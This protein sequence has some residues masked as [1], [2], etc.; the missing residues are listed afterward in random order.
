MLNILLSVNDDKGSTE[1]GLKKTFEKE[2][3]ECSFKSVASLVAIKSAMSSEK[4][5]AL[6]TAYQIGTRPFTVEE[7]SDI[8]ETNEDMRL[9]VVIPRD[10][11]GT[12]FLSEL[13]NAGIFCAVFEN[14]AALSY[15]VTMTKEGRTRKAARSYYG[16]LDDRINAVKTVVNPEKIE[17]LRQ[18]LLYSDDTDFK[19]R[20]DYIDQNVEPE[21]MTALLA[22]I[23]ND[24]ETIAQI[25]SYPEYAKYFV[26]EFEPKQRT[27]QS[28]NRRS[29]GAALSGLSEMLSKVGSRTEVKI[30]KELVARK[31]IGVAGLYRGAG[32]TTAAVSLA[33]TISE[34]ESVTYIEIPNNGMVVYGRYEL[35][36][37]IGPDFLS[38]P[39]LVAEGNVD[40]SDVNNVYEGINFFV[41]NDA[42]GNVT[43]NT[44]ELATIL[45]GTSDNVVVDF[46]CSVEEAKERGFLNMLT[47]MVIVCEDIRSEEYLGKL[48]EEADSLKSTS[49]IPFILTL[50]EK[51]AS[52]VFS[53]NLISSTAKKSYAPDRVLPLNISG[54]EKRRLL[55][56]LEIS[57]TKKKRDKYIRQVIQKG[58]VEVAV[59]GLDKGSGTTHTA[60][61]LA[62]SVRQNYKVAYV[63]LNGS[64]QM[65]ALAHELEYAPG[66]VIHMYGIDI[67]YDV[68][69]RVFAESYRNKYNYVVL[70]FGSLKEL[71]RKRDLFSMCAKKCLCIDAAPWKL[72]KIEEH[73]EVIEELDKGKEIMVF[74][75]AADKSVVKGYD[76]YQ[77]VGKREIIR[78]PFS[79]IP[80]ECD[81]KIVTYLSKILA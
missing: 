68:D 5:D 24:K 73:I 7:L 13:L 6:I 40:L 62:D 2:G 29:G 65:A 12:T 47:H 66:E 15:L 10:L 46:G 50:S 30:K 49:L 22:L 34:H 36:E 57:G 20:L 56:Y 25:R 69:Y 60:L 53:F 64:G 9:I 54:T 43:L 17:K 74:L 28:E 42:Y 41:G 33:K 8:H 52:K 23:S 31:I 37:N 76:I 4:Y 61:M 70:D 1:E 75:P 58:V 72:Y 27:P 35:E 51:D 79:R 14:E 16:L 39:H 59:F 26:D 38:V 67:Y 71:S 11:Y 32:A 55:E 44:S 3:I 78:V 45:N 19:G 77:R 21:E 63:E 80:V 48:K 81:K 18:Y